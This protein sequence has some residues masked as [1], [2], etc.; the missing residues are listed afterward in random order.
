[1]IPQSWIYINQSAKLPSYPLP[2]RTQKMG[3]T[4]RRLLTS[5]SPPPQFPLPIQPPAITHL[6]RYFATEDFGHEIAHV[7]LEA[8]GED[9]EV[10]GEGGTVGE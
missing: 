8:G 5:I 1:M 9:N 7:A 10:R 4:E 6:L 3:E 2:K